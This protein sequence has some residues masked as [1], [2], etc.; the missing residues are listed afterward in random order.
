M[1]NIFVVKENYSYRKI[2]VFVRYLLFDKPLVFM[3]GGK[4]K[5]MTIIFNQKFFNENGKCD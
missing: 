1:L 2:K 3:R 4:K 5:I